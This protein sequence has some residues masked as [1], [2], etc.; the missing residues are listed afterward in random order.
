MAKYL[1]TKVAFMFGSDPIFKET[2][3]RMTLN[4]GVETVK[5]KDLAKGLAKIDKEMSGGLADAIF[6]KKALN[7]NRDILIRKPL[8][9]LQRELPQK[10][11]KKVEEVYN[12]IDD[13]SEQL[14][15]EGVLSADK[16]GETLGEYMHQFYKEY[17]EANSKGMIFGKPAIRGTKKLKE[18]LTQEGI[19][20][21][22]RIE[23]PAYVLGRTMM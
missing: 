10:T 17:L 6:T 14:V 22:G 19:E 20:K 21:L 12:K 15:K 8:S 3:Q 11:F 18:D 13:L 2:W 4:K 9:Q 7:T 23:N 5:A 16:K 1:A